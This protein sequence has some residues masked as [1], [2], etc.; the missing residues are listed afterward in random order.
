[1]NL[2]I[3]YTGRKTSLLIHDS[4]PYLTTIIIK[5]GS[6]I[7][8]TLFGNLKQGVYTPE[9][10]RAIKLKHLSRISCH[11][12]IKSCGRNKV[13]RNKDKRKKPAG[14]LV[15]HHMQQLP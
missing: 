6:Q 13:K 11:G 15:L 3:Y 1:M 7:E 2:T 8:L 9:R 12:L 4:N 5:L 10:E 14:L